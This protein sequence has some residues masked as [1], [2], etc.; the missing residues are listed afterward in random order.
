M[1]T[2]A[3][4]VG[5]LIGLMALGLVANAQSD[6]VISQYIETNSGTTPKGIEIFNISGADIDFSVTNLQIYQ[7]TNG[8]SCNAIGATLITSG[9]WQQTKFGLSEQLT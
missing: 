6:V 5:V 8:G 1:K 4:R 3:F 2:I 7:G 9:H